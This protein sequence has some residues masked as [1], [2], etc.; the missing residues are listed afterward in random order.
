MFSFIEG[1]RKEGGRR[2]CYRLNILCI[3]KQ[4]F[5]Q[6]EGAGLLQ[7]PPF[8]C[9]LSPLCPYI[10]TGIFKKKAARGKGI[11]KHKFNI[12]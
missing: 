11:G 8:P 10:G 9:L 1:V 5:E 6:S 3:S 7:T 2:K 4:C 12:E